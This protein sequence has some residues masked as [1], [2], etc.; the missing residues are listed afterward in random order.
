[1]RNE[2][3]GCVRFKKKDP[4]ATASSI[5]FLRPGNVSSHLALARLMVSN[6]LF[7]SRDS[8]SEASK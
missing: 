5:D 1:M 3:D 6:N 8:C 7:V 2:L 4:R